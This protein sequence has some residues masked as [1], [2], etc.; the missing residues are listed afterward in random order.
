MSISARAA[1][2]VMMAARGMVG[3]VCVPT[4][5][6]FGPYRFYVFAHENQDT[7]EG[8]H[9]HVRSGNGVAAFWLVPVSLRDYQRYNPR[10]LERIRRIVI[11]NRELLLRHWHDF[12]DQRS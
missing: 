1:S 10:E 12:F 2:L 4:V 5:H 6:R 9:F 8:P 3:E 7:F 11:A